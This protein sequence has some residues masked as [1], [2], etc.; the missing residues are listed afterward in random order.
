MFSIDTLV[1]CGDI[2]VHFINDRLQTDLDLEL[3]DILLA[4]SPEESNSLVVEGP[5]ESIKDGLYRITYEVSLADYPLNSE[6]SAES[7]LITILPAPN[8]SQPT[9]V[10]IA[11]A[12][13]VAAAGFAIIYLAQKLILKYLV[14][15]SSER[16]IAAG[17]ESIDI[18]NSFNSS[19]ARTN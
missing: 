16:R 6:V 9:P 14:K 8:K 5:A 15:D 1:D 10:V 2:E 17:N 12:V 7:F 4:S 18:Q 3:F 19:S 11:F 13:I